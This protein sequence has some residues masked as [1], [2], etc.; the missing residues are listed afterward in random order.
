[1]YKLYL[2]WRE[3]DLFYQILK[4]F[5]QSPLM[6]KLMEINEEKLMEINVFDN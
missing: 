6:K 4:C 5:L 3:K 1:M 2:Q